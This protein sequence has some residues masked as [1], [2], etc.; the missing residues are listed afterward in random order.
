MHRQ[1]DARRD[2]DRDPFRDRGDV[3]GLPLSTGPLG[4]PRALGHEP[5]DAPTPDGRRP[6]PR[7]RPA[8]AIP[9]RWRPRSG[10]GGRHTRRRFC[11][12]LSEE[13][14]RSSCGDRMGLPLL[15]GEDPD[16]DDLRRHF[17]S[18]AR[19]GSEVVSTPLQ[20][21]RGTGL[22]ATRLETDLVAQRGLGLV[23]VLGSMSP[24][25]EDS[26]VLFSRQMNDACNRA[27]WAI[28]SFGSVRLRCLGRDCR[29]SA[30]C[31]GSLTCE[32]AQCSSRAGAR[33]DGRPWGVRRV[34]GARV[35]G[36]C[37]MRRASR[38][39]VTQSFLGSRGQVDRI[40]S[41]RSGYGQLDR[42]SPRSHCDPPTRSCEPVIGASREPTCTACGRGP[43]GRAD[44]SAAGWRC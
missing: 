1:R 17:R 4:R 7:K 12:S 30:N 18:I 35:Y 32:P 22:R 28:S 8:T 5:P 36:V 9:G 20:V 27:S 24:E 10:A 15:T 6:R 34:G 11:Q 39:A 40:R 26:F 23:V 44:P 3:R 29:L 19:I 38:A 43:R 37:P 21:A 2:R 16:M 42:S 41:L 31:R 33:S 13:V 25:L 14:K